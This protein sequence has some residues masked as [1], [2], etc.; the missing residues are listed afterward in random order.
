VRGTSLA[1]VGAV[2][3]AKDAADAK[4]AA[5]GSSLASIHMV[6]LCASR[7][8]RPVLFEAMSAGAF[9]EYDWPLSFSVRVGAPSLGRFLG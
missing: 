5:D 3:E 2:G 1:P 7:E 9:P 6:D 8:G 4:G